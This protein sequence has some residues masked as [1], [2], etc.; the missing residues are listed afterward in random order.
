[1]S[2]RGSLGA[3]VIEI[4]VASLSSNSSGVTSE[5]SGTVYR[6]HRNN[7]AAITRRP[8]VAVAVT[9]LLGLTELKVVGGRSYHV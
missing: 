2:L 6:G 1:M 9:G 8:G 4:V 7:W 5:S 3:A